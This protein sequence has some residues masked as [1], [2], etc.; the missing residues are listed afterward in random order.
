MVVLGEF[1]GSTYFGERTRTSSLPNI[2][3]K[4]IT[5]Y[6]IFIQEN[7]KGTIFS[8]D[9]GWVLVECKP[10]TEVLLPQGF[11]LGCDSSGCEMETYYSPPTAPY[12]SFDPSTWPTGVVCVSEITS[13][14]Y[15]PEEDEC[16]CSDEVTQIMPTT[17]DLEPPSFEGDTGLTPVERVEWAARE[18]MKK[19]VRELTHPDVKYWDTS[20]TFPCYDCLGDLKKV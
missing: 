9:K 15:D 4:Q 19:I 8:F 3:C 12:D 20:E 1:Y 13:A 14:P 18:A 10:A 17:N 5:F 2:C 16:S 7:R 11:G 6:S